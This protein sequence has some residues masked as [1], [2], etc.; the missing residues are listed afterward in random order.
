[1][2]ATT[3]D[4]RGMVPQEMTGNGSFA[5]GSEVLDLA[6]GVMN[7][8][9]RFLDSVVRFIHSVTHD[10]QLYQLVWLDDGTGERSCR[11]QLRDGRF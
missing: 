10:K 6:V 2:Q 8:R 9:L 4:I 11:R 5:G 7:N 1:M 3:D